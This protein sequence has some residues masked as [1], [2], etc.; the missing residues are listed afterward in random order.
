MPKETY[1]VTLARVFVLN[2]FLN[3][4]LFEVIYSDM[5]HRIGCP[6]V[7]TRGSLHLFEEYYPRAVCTVDNSI[8]VN[9]ITGQYYKEVP[10]E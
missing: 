10:R 8:Y 9:Y 1:A 2:S 4:E 6:K 7:G 3:P 5:P